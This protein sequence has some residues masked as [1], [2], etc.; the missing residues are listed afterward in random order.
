MNKWKLTLQTYQSVC[1]WG[2]GNKGTI[3]NKRGTAL[4]PILVSQGLKSMV[5]SATC[6]WD[7][8]TNSVLTQFWLNEHYLYLSHVVYYDYISLLGDGRS[9]AFL[10]FSLHFPG[11][12]NG[13]NFCVVFCAHTTNSYL[14]SLPNEC[15]S[16]FYIQIIQIIYQ[17]DI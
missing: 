3:T 12:S 10:F 6:T 8:K 4:S 2:N 16:S 15:I 13:L 1:I 7:L 11:V 14:N 17:I 5:N 9:I